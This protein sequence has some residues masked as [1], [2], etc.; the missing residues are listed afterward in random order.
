[1]NKINFQSKFETFVNDNRINKIQRE[2][3]NNNNNEH[4]FRKRR[5]HFHR[6]SLQGLPR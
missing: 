1:M 6:S 4:R 2:R 5:L 3:T